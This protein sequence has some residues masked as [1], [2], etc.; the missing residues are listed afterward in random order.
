MLVVKLCLNLC[1]FI[2]LPHISIE[3]NTVELGG[4]GV[5]ILTT[6]GNGIVLG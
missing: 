6:T 2:A 1:L 4:D 5:K 3:K